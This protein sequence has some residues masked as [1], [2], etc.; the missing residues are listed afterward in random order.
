MFARPRR[1]SR[2]MRLASCF[3]LAGC[4]AAPR[5]PAPGEP[6][7]TY[8]TSAGDQVRLDPDGGCLEVVHVPGSKCGHSILLRNDILV[9]N[10]LAALPRVMQREPRAA[11]AA[12]SS[13]RLGSAGVALGWIGTATTPLIG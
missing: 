4:V 12:R 8:M 10:G 1:Q 11:R 13:E 7:I 2:V 5:L 6:E 9:P 3:V